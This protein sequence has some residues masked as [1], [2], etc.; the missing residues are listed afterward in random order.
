MIGHGVTR[1][2]L[3]AA[4]ASG[5]LGERLPWIPNVDNSYQILGW[6]QYWSKMI[7]LKLP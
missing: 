5:W 4:L 1:S 3:D 2:P 7:Q 6:T